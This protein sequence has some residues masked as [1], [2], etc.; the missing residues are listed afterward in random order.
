MRSRGSSGCLA[1][2]GA[3]D[4]ALALEEHRLQDG[5][6]VA[7]RGGTHHEVVVAA[8]L[9]GGPGT[10]ALLGGDEPL[11]H[12]AGELVVAEAQLDAVRRGGAPPALVPD[13]LG[14]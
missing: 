7:G 5:W 4:S 9:P 6:A 14:L 8:D 10:A 2:H 11:Q 13:L 3:P 1:D 12:L